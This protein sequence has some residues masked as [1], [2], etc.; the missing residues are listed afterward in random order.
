[1]WTPTHWAVDSLDA[2][3]WRGLSV[4]AALPPVAAMLGF[5]L[6]FSAVALARFQWDE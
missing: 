3:N 5:R 2:V 6:L 4:R 1:M